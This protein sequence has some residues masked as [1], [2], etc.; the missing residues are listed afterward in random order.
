MKMEKSLKSVYHKRGSSTLGFDLWAVVHGLRDCL[1]IDHVIWRQSKT[2][3]RLIQ[4]IHR[5]LN[6]MKC[7]DQSSPILAFFYFADQLF[8]V[9]AVHFKTRIFTDLQDEY[10]SYKFINVSPRI[11]CPRICDKAELESIHTAL[12]QIRSILSRKVLNHL[13]HRKFKTSNPDS[14]GTFNGCRSQRKRRGHKSKCTVRGQCI[15][16]QRI[17]GQ[18]LNGIDPCLYPTICGYLLRFPFVYYTND[19]TSH[20]LNLHKLTLLSIKYEG[21]NLMQFSVPQKM[22]DSEVCGDFV[23]T[24]ITAFHGGDCPSSVSVS[25]ERLDQIVSL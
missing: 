2:H 17:D 10:G 21:Y 12:K 6:G 1:L 4:L 16:I 3:S 14:S 19:A 25:R 20:C 9:N 18:D 5:I 13:N 7:V 24:A 8:I 22:M 11:K 23:N 15:D